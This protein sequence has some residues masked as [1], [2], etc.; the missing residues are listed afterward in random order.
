MPLGKYWRSN[1]L[2]FSLVPRCHGLW[3]VAE[4]D[5]HAA[6]DRQACVLGHLGPLQ[7]HVGT[8]GEAA[9][10]K[11]MI[12]ARDGVTHGLG[13][14]SGEREEQACHAG[15]MAMAHH[16]RQVPQLAGVGA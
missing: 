8:T 9:E 6:V 5:L 13:T 14:V 1:P 15:L 11:V 2:V 10:G 3:R 12:I 7:S 16:A 4:V